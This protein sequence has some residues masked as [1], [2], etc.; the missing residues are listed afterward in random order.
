MEIK[1]KIML[2]GITYL[3]GIPMLKH[4]FTMKM[5]MQC[6]SQRL[7]RLMENVIM[8]RSTRNYF[9]NVLLISCA[10]F[11]YTISQDSHSQNP[12]N[13]F[14][15][16]IDAFI[17]DDSVNPPPQHSIEFIGSSVFTRWIN[18]KEQMN[19]LPVFNR[20]FG[21]SSTHDVLYFMDKIV[22]PY[23][24]KIIVYYCGSNDAAGSVPADNII[25][26]IEVFFERVEKQL[27]KTKIFFVSVNRSPARKV[28]W[29]TIDSTNAFIKTFC[30]KSSRRE[31]IDVNP[32][33]FD[34][35]GNPRLELYLEDQ[36]HFKE[37]AYEEFTKIIKPILLQEWSN[38]NA[39]KE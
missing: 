13:R 18:L 23:N 1:L 34:S 27:P 10:L 16:A 7:S 37:R 20:A 12:K 30:T 8:K 15:P 36:L 24:P 33:L 25:S 5:S 29:S 6:T 35:K 3:I 2:Y 4:F 19:P 31:F 39:K 28:K 38:T 21:G 17:K 32:I 14:Q 26:N 22:F 9:W 11:R